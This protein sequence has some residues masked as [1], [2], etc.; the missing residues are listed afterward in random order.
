MEYF[1]VK[2]C[3]PMFQLASNTCAMRI[4]VG[5]VLLTNEATIGEGGEQDTYTGGPAASPISPRWTYFGSYLTGTYSTGS[6]PSAS[7]FCLT[8]RGT[9]YVPNMTMFAD[10]PAGE[11]NNSQRDVRNVVIMSR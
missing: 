2:V 9:N 3:F 8:Y 6:N 4:R 7:L 10:A 5:F 11:V 1:F